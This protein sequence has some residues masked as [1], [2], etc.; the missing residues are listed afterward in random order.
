MKNSQIIKQIV[1]NSICSEDSYYN[2]K[3]EEL[4]AIPNSSIGFDEEE[5]QQIFKDKL[6]KIVKHKADFIK[7]EAIE[8]AESFKIMELFTAQMPEI[9]LKQI[10]KNILQNKKPFQ[11]F[12]HHIDASTFRESWFAFQQNELEKIV[13]KEVTSLLC[14][15]KQ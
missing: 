11:R 13:A 15:K 5:F 6:E 12:K 4:I 1:Q 3:T 14:L 8:S 7:I 2:Y 9:E 10:L